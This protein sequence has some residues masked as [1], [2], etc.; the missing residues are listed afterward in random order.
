M[1]DTTDFFGKVLKVIGKGEV[2][3]KQEE[4]GETK[5]HKKGAQSGPSKTN[6]KES[7]SKGKDR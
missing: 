2:Y 4:S 7:N 6:S 5:N 1:T 3:G